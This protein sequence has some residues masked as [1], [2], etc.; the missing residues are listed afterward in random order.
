MTWE[1]N[2]TKKL[3]VKN[4]MLTLSLVKQKKRHVKNMK[5]KICDARKIDY[6]LCLKIDYY[7]LVALKVE[8]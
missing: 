4:Y 2:I 1:H 8:I 3:F 7:A 6:F 5:K